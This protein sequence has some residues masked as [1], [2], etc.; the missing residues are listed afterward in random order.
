MMSQA[1]LGKHKQLNMRILQVETRGSIRD[2][3]SHGPGLSWLVRDE[4]QFWI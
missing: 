2:H 1:F 3:T 4:G